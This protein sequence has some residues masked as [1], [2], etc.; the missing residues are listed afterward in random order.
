MLLFPAKRIIN[1]KVECKT[2]ALHSTFLLQKTERN[3]MGNV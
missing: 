1:K 3:N 2:L